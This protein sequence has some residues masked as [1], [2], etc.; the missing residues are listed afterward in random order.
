MGEVQR[1]S[2]MISLTGEYSV[3]DHDRLEGYPKHFCLEGK[4]CITDDV[5]VGGYFLPKDAM[6]YHNLWEM[7]LDPQVWRDP[8]VFKPQRFFLFF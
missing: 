3:Q 8:H 5:V 1:L 7:N 2:S 4:A 6:I